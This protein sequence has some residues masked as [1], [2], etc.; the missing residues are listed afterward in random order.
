MSWLGVD[1]GTSSVKAAVVCADGRIGALGQRRYS[2]LNPG[3]G[4]YELDP[5]AVWDAARGAIW[6]AVQ[7]SG[8]E[9]V[10]AICSSSLGE[11]FVLLDREGREICN[12]PMFYDQSG[13]EELGAL[14]HQM[15]A[16]AWLRG[17]GLP[18]GRQ[19]TLPKLMSLF[20]RQPELSRSAVRLNFFA[21]YL[22]YKLGGPHVTDASLAST[23]MMLS[24]SARDWWDEAL[25]CGRIGRGLLPEVR[26]AGTDLG[27]VRGEIADQL[28][29][30]RGARLILG[31]HDQMMCAIGARVFDEGV[32]ANSMGTTDAMTPLVAASPRAE[33]TLDGGFRLSPFSAIPGLYYSSVYNLCGGAVNEWLAGA[34]GAAG[35]GAAEFYLRMEARMPEGPS[36]ALFV[37]AFSGEGG[38]A[39]MGLRFDTTLED[40]YRALLEGQAFEIKR[41]LDRFEACCAPIRSIHAVGGSARSNVNLQLRADIFNKRIDR[42]AF[43]EA[44]V[45]GCAIVAGAATGGFKGVQATARA[46][47]RLDAAFEPDGRRH[48]RYLERFGEYLRRR[49]RLAL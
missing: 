45:L 39:L 16:G 33:R 41:D 40:A 7:G 28:G 6:Q 20:R 1:I 38:G 27:A 31:G 8:G 47:A 48:E 12:S 18:P 32:A 25:E 10:E 11:S 15:D 14:L 29:L 36:P 37:P 34:L 46:L 35:S 26:P 22:I 44:G 4:R 13:D 30:D 49:E 42:M 19:L 2:L 17:A 9:R 43:D 21:D 5:R 3:P 23:S 24:Y